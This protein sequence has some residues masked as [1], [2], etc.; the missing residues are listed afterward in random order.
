[1]LL[2]DEMPCIPL[3]LKSYEFSVNRREVLISPYSTS[4]HTP[5]PIQIRPAA[6]AGQGGQCGGCGKGR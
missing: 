1:M 5:S 4:L 2:I 3:R 6:D